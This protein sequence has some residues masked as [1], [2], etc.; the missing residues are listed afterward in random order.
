MFLL[1][2]C[3]FSLI[4]IFEMD[5][6]TNLDDFNKLFADYQKRF[7]RF[8]NSFVRDQAVAEDIT[9]DSFMYYWEN[10]HSLNHD[11]NIPA[12]ILTTVKHKCLNYLEHIRVREEYA[13]SA[14]SH[15]A[16]ELNL[17]IS[18]LEACEPEELF[19]QEIQC[20]VDKALQSLPEQTREVFV[21]S[22]YE[23]KSNKEIAV[24]LNISVKGVE[25]H[26]TK[27]LSLLRKVLKEYLYLFF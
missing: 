1:F 14:K 20:M 15:A 24:A 11:T 17:R 5:I 8:A 7:I 23:N 18:T 26:I 4:L 22:R 12:Y 13:E 3:L 19:S 25:Y 21:M 9:V 27:T 16:W 10:R 6:N 2:L